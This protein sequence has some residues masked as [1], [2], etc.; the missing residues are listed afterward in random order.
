MGQKAS[1]PKSLTNLKLIGEGAQGQ[2]FQY[3]TD[4]VIKCV[5]ERDFKESFINKASLIGVGPRYYGSVR[6]DGEICYIQEMLYKVNLSEGKYDKRLSELITKLIENGLF[7]NDLKSDN[8]MKNKKG[9]LKLIDFDMATNI[10][11]YGYK[12]FDNKLKN[13]SEYKLLDENNKEIKLVKLEFSKS[14]INRIKKMRPIIEETLMEKEKAE[15]LKQARER[16]REEARTRAQSR[17]S[18][19]KLKK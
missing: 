6:K 10:S 1:V 14:Q 18:S 8:I 3:T 4:K 2:V 7:H 15:Q 17:L 11:D 5:N 13:N 19:Y 9:S 12:S 16:A